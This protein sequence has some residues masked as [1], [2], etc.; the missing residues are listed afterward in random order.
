MLGGSIRKLKSSAVAALVA[1]ALAAA[2]PSLAQ[3]TRDRVL[4]VAVA[5][6]PASVDSE[7]A[8]TAEGETMMA[9][10][11]GGDLFAYKVVKNSQYGVDEVDLKSVGDQGVV[12]RFAD[13]WT[14]DD[15]GK[16]ITVKLKHGIKSPYGNE[17][18]AADYRWSW[19][20]RFAM[21]S[22]GKFMGDVLG[23][24]GPDSVEVVDPSTV[25]FHLRG[26][27]PIFFKLLAQCYYGGPFDATEAKKHATA[28][29]PW[30]KEWLRTHSDGFGPYQVD[31]VTPGSETI[32]TLNPNWSGPPPFFNRVIMKVVPNSSARLSL[33][34]AGQVDI[35]WDL[36]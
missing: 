9:N 24:D 19:D 35:A 16:T 7:Q 28:A 8:P 25:R 36:S 5:T 31:K 34:K 27:S 2:S 4:V 14:V 11:V 29:D 32:L 15:G 22:V 10:T 33:L 1:A 13:S 30:A 21:K 6:T 20:R 26:P 3:S 18:T 12:G 17:F 23:L